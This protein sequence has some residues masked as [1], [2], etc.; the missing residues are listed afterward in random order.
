METTS[1]GGQWI[2]TLN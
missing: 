2:G 1:F